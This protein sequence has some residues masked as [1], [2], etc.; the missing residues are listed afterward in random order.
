MCHDPDSSP[1]IEPIPGAVAESGDLTLTA[2]DGNEF[3]AYSATASQPL[4]PGVVILPDVRGLYRF[5]EELAD[6][7]A[8][9]GY[10][11]I[12]FD[13]FGRTAGVGKRGDDFPYTEH[14]PLTTIE[15]IAA[16]T[17]AAVGKL[18]EVQPD[19]KV[20][21]IG[22]C[23]GGSGSW[24]QAAEGH[25]LSGAIGFYGNPKRPP[26]GPIERVSDFECPIL[27]LMGGQDQGIP[28]DVVDEYE[29]ALSAAGVE[30]EVVTYPD[31]EHS[32]FDRKQDRFGSEAADAWQR[33]LGFLAG[34]AG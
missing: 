28:A 20:F 10:D 11:A 4:G 27:A 26:V 23:F 33:V 12:A 17:S 24:H 13:Y 9:H 32:F 22:F 6:R 15:G 19:R 18:R 14:V 34:N 2:S 29:R 31:A 8:E 7:L 5:Y 25:G 3:A 16:D 30:H 1:P 21:T